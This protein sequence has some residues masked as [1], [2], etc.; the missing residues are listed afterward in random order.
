L[1]RDAARAKRTGQ[2]FVL[3]FIDVDNLKVVN[4]SLGHAAGDTLLRDVANAVRARVRSYD[5]LI[6]FGGD[7]FVC[8]LADLSM[9]AAAAR[10][11]HV[12]ADLAAQHASIAVGLAELGEHDE[13]EDL[14]ARAD[15]AMYARRQQPRLPGA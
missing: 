15:L 8:G 14:L 10:F 9:E 12:N 11:G 2:R 7:E 4:D 13:L 5:L 3:A 6:R 1:T